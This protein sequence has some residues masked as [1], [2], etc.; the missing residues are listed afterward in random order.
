MPRKNALN[1]HFMVKLDNKYSIAKMSLVSN[2]SNVNLRSFSFFNSWQ[3]LMLS[4]T[5]VLTKYKAPLDFR[6]MT[7]NQYST[8]NIWT[9]IKW[10][11]MIASNFLHP[12]ILSFKEPVCQKE[13]RNG[14]RC[15]GPNRYHARKWKDD[16]SMTVIIMLI[17]VCMCLWL[18]RA[19]LWDWLSNRALLQ[20][21]T[22]LRLFG[23]IA[24]FSRKATEGQCSSQLQGV[25]CT[26]QLCCATL[27][28]RSLLN[29]TFVLIFSLQISH[30]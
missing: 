19:L 20:V 4:P 28:A 13:C 8:W 14:G 9:R 1:S 11:H 27:G 23:Q 17:Q 18:H 25:V 24:S 12:V 6:Q 5:F 29:D 3:M 21:L 15:I 7:L 30:F 2:V 10:D 16:H 26:R 22:D